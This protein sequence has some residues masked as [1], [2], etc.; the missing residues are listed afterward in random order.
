MSASRFASHVHACVLC[1]VLTTTTTTRANNCCRRGPQ[2]YS[3]A[4]QY[5][6][7]LLQQQPNNRQ[8]VELLRAIEAHVAAE[9]R[10]GLA[11]A[12]TIAA[13]ALALGVLVARLRR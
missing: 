5:V 10:M 12:G 1:S 9:G 2:D 3:A 13:G 8:G 6:Q 7:Q 4:R 11:I